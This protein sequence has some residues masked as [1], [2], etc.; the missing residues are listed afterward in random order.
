MAITRSSKAIT[1]TDM[2]H[3]RKRRARSVALVAMFAS[4]GLAGASAYFA[5][6]G[7]QSANSTVKAAPAATVDAGAPS[8]FDPFDRLD[9]ERWYVSDG[10]VNGNHQ[11]C[12]WSRENLAIRKGVLQLTLGKA[13]DRL[14]PYRCAEIHTNARLSYGTYEIRIRTAAGS[15]LNTAM[16][17]YVAPPH[18]EIDFEF[19]GKDSSGVQLNYFTK[20]KGGH[21]SFNRPGFDAAAG[22][23]DYAFVWSPSSLRW[24]INGK[25]IREATE[26]G[27]PTTP[28]S[29]FVSLWNGSKE[30]DAWLGPMDVSRSPAIAEVDWIG[31]TR[32]GERCRFPT[33]ITCKL[34]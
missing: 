4:L 8:F 10:W 18:D 22:F 26:A 12:T 31:F 1:S 33:S 32:A 24:Y 5:T 27:R 2:T 13:K 6:A 29:M 17:T 20:G 25:L 15:G 21:E 7:A 28:A 23:N 19:L 9:S 3:A 34:P 11:G 14:R 30:S 16:F